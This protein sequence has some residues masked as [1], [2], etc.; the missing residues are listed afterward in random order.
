MVHQSAF[1]ELSQIAPAA[2]LTIRPRYSKLFAELLSQTKLGTEPRQAPRQLIRI[3]EARNQCS[4]V[5]MRGSIQRLTTTEDW[6]Q[7]SCGTLNS[8]SQVFSL[9][10]KHTLPTRGCSVTSGSISCRSWPHMSET[11]CAFSRSQPCR[12]Q[13][14]SDELR[15]GP[16][17]HD[18]SSQET[19]GRRP[20]ALEP[21]SLRLL[22][23]SLS[24]V[25]HGHLL[26]STGGCKAK[27]NVLGRWARKPTNSSCWLCQSSVGGMISAPRT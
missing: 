16:R 17:N 9:G 23:S 19:R 10:P 13:R 2:R 27:R 3:L 22:D 12:D 1:E 11:T 7:H 21:S 8:L 4:S 24:P 25:V 26:R 14:S 5:C 15:C 6:N 20:T 18:A